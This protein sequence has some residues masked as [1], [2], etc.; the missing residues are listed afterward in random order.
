MKL[1][2][3]RPLC[4]L[5]LVIIVAIGS[6]ML[7]L[8]LT[9]L[10]AAI[11]FTILLWSKLPRQFKIVAMSL[12]IIAVIS[13]LLTTCF[14]S[15]PTYRT[16]DPHTGLRGVILKYVHWY[17]SLFLSEDNANLIYNMLNII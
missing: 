8:W 14:V 9:F 13:Y 12:Y 3:F 10:G 16:Y 5:A 6:A 1:C 11:L 4:W 17:L 2:N 7:S 15:N